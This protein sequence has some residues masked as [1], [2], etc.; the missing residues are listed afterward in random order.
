MDWFGA[1][2]DTLSC[3]SRRKNGRISG[4]PHTKD[5]ANQSSNDSDVPAAPVRTADLTL[6]L[7]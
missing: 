3:E 4:E 2:A 6:T 5:N 1:L 7:T